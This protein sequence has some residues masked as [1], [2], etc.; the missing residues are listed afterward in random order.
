MKPDDR[1]A[2]EEDV[3]GKINSMVINRQDICSNMRQR[4]KDIVSTI[5]RSWRE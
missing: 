3:C 2:E 5:E 4:L 1:I